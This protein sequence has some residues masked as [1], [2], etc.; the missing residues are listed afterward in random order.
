VPAEPV[1][2]STKEVV[3]MTLYEKLSLLIAIATLI[4]TILK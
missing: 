4:A 1:S 2:S 3:R